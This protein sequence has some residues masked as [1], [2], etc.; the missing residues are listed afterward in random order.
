M[1]TGF[2][3]VSADGMPIIG[4]A[5]LA[6]LYYATGHGASGVGPAPGTAALL[7]ALILGREP[8]IA[9]EPFRPDRFRGA[10]APAPH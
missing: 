6:G 3:P 8:P 9:A 7:A 5:A 10:A 1:W 2:R 4:P